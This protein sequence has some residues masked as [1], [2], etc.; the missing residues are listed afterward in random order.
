MSA[1]LAGSFT[2]RSSS[3]SASTR[4]CTRRAANSGLVDAGYY[5]IDW[6]RIEKGYR[7][8]GRELTPDVNPY[9]AGLAF[10]CDRLDSRTFRGKRV[11]RRERPRGRRPDRGACSLVVDAPHTKL[12]GGEPILRNGAPAGFVTSAAFGHTIGKPVALGLVSNAHGALDAAW[13]DAGRYKIDLAGERY[14]AAVSLK[15][16]YD[17]ASSRTKK[18]GE[19]MLVG[20]P[21]EIK[22]HEYRVGLT[23]SSVREMAAHGH[24]VL[25][26]TRCRHRHR[27][28]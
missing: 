17:P 24:E 2:C 22:V 13:L 21:K 16:P 1:S 10:A 9:E 14:A 26:Q 4:R 28:Q 15:A 5:A 6:L 11:L 7:A 18:L 19:P 20:V 27:C 8:W 12:W 25:V 23:P 3:R